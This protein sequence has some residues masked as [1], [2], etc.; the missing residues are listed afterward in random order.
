MLKVAEALADAWGVPEGGVFGDKSPSYCEKWRQLKQEFP[1]CRFVMTS[2]DY[3]ETV[4]SV[5]RQDWG[6]DDPGAREWVHRCILSL[7]GIQDALHVSLE[8]L[9]ED[10]RQGTGLLLDW[11]GLD[12]ESYPW[13]AALEYVRTTRIN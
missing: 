8:T 13:D 10:L 11:V 6:C 5:L 1:K 9:N 12:H 4:Q 3:E 7:D 2:R